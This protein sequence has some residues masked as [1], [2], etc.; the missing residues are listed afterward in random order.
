ML[1]VRGDVLGT[2]AGQVTPLGAR[3]PRSRRDVIRVKQVSVVWM[4]G[5]V[6]GAVLA[7]QKLF[8]KPG[9]VGTVPFGRAGVRHGL[10]KLIFRRERGG[11]ALG[12]IPD[13]LIGGQQAGREIT[14]R[15]LGNGEGCRGGG[16]G[17]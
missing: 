13:N 14:M 17:R 1:A 15:G 10:H 11:P 6:A 3:M 12:F 4:I 7:E 2:G 8:E 16:G 9:G 5:R